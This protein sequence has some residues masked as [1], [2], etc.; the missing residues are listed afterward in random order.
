MQ[1][2]LLLC[3]ISAA[4]FAV[5]L[6][7]SDA[8]EPATLTITNVRDEVVANASD[9]FYYK[10]TTLLLTN[11]AILTDDTNSARQGLS[12]VDIEL[13]IGN[14][15]TSTAFAGSAQVETNV[16]RVRRVRPG[17]N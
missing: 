5:A 2:K 16:H 3:L 14:A 15:V 12:E 11:C 7:A 8:V 9:A 4:L 13:K 10:G 6:W 1:N 17:G